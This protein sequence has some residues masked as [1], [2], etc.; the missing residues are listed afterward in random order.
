M[1]QD[2]EKFA[3]AGRLSSTLVPL[4]FLFRVRLL[5]FSRFHAL[6]IYVSH[7]HLYFPVIIHAIIAVS[8]TYRVTHRIL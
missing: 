2:N 7:S 1:A 4:N 8:L 3:S 6:Q 5:S